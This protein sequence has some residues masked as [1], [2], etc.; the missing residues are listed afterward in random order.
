[1]GQKQSVV[2]IFAL[3]LLLAAGLMTLT[4]SFISVLNDILAYQLVIN[5]L[6]LLIFA[7]SSFAFIIVLYSI[8]T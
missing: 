6:I 1:M 2:Q 8:H 4:Y 3:M 7:Y 5:K